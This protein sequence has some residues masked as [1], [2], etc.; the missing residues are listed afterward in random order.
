MGQ[1]Q[2]RCGHVD[3]KNF[4]KN[5]YFRKKIFCNRHECNHQKCNGMKFNQYYCG[6][7]MWRGKS[8]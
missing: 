8:K 2:S 4:F 1:K 6:K 3:C 7:H 5:P